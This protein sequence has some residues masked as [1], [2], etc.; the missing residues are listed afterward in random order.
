MT[1]S[2]KPATIAEYHE[3][4]EPGD[5]AICDKLR[6]LI[7]THLPD[8]ESRMW[9]GHPVTFLDDNPIVGYGRL[10]GC[11]RLMF[12]SG[13]SFPTSGLKPDGNFK[14]ASIRYSDAGQI[15]PKAVQA[16][17]ADA[18]VYQWDYK[19]IVKHKGRLEPLF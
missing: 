16:W 6:R 13:Q 14:A 1:K 9:H 4:C 5:R 15:D 19:N 18:A 7:S 12:W 10:K 2:V 11:V 17:L 8:A 3:S